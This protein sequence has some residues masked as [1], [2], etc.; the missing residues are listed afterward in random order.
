MLKV[1]LMSYT[2]N[3]EEVIASS[4]KLC[5]SPV[6]VDKIMEKQDKENID[7][8]L[9]KLSSIGHLS[10]FEHASFT[11]AI[12]GVSR[13]LTH[14]LVRHRIAS[15]S[16]QSQR[17]VK[18][19]SFEYIMP[20]AIRDNEDACK[21]FLRHMEASQKAY[22]EIVDAIMLK[23]LKKDRDFSKSIFY[24]VEKR[25]IEDA[26]YV[27]PNATETKIVLTMNARSLLHFFNMRCCNRAQWEIR[28]LADKMLREAIKIAPTLFSR[29][30]A[31]CTFGRCPEGEMTCGE[32]RS[33]DDVLKLNE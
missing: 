14:Q 17:Y 24:E 27:F 21:V 29:S 7:K 13:V 32:P 19:N 4:A 5:Y 8:F 2:A 11:F 20:P 26:R 25:A 30:G 31:P 9:E 28:D 10:S 6:G 16:Q 1:S 33:I 18:E 23:E 3:P 12:E 15:Y 22:D